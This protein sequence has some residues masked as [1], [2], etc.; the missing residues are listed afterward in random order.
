[1]VAKKRHFPARVLFGALSRMRKLGVRIEPFLVVRE[2]EESVEVPVSPETFRFG[3]LDANGIDE[4]L[5][6]EPSVDREELVV[7]FSAG[8]RCYG[9]WDSSRLVAKMWCDLDEFSYPPNFRKLENDEAY[10]YAAFTDPEYRGMSLAPMMRANC[11]NSLRAMGRNR[12]Y[13]YT[14]YFNTPARRFKLKLGA[15]DE[16]LRLHLQLFGKWSSTI[17]L[18]KY[19]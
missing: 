4:L 7:W 2:A 1:M 18:R 10:I 3:Y 8:K 11:Y 12:L 13:S 9:V 5:R 17:T 6:L 19:A 15:R 14:D 16:C